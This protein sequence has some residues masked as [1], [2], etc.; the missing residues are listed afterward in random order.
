MT[1]SDLKK[2]RKYIKTANYDDVD[3]DKETRKSM[4]RGQGLKVQ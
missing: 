2:H 4:V 1:L 3:K